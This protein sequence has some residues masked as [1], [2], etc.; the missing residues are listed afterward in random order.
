MVDLP[1]LGCRARDRG[2]Q[3][4]AGAPSCEWVTRTSG[5]TPSPSVGKLRAVRT[6]TSTLAVTRPPAASPRG[7]KGTQTRSC[8]LS[9]LME[10]A[11]EQIASVYNAL[12]ILAKDG[13]W[14]GGSGGY[15]SSAGWGRWRL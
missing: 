1:G 7:L 15:S 5:R 3:L 2:A 6:S 8:S 11:A 10:E 14:A 13:R 9:V 12:V 4:A